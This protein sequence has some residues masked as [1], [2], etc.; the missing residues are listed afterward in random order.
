MDA[1]QFLK[2]KTAQLCQQLGAVEAQLV[3]L[4]AIKAKLIAE[5]KTLDTIAPQLKAQKPQEPA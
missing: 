2:A 4:T 3:E 5:L 1:Q